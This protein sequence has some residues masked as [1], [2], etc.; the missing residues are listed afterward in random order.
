[1]RQRRPHLL[2]AQRKPEERSRIKRSLAGPFETQD[3][4]KPGRYTGKRKAAGLRGLR[5]ALRGSCLRFVMGEE[6]FQGLDYG[7]GGGGWV[8]CTI[9]KNHACTGP[10]PAT[11]PPYPYAC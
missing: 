8:F 5:P 2:D 6:I 9:S 3:K 11:P 1:M 4:L 7:G 10:H